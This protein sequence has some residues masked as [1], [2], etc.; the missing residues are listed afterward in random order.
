MATSATRPLDISLLPYS[1]RIL[2]SSITV[3]CFH[4]PVE[5]CSHYF[6][7][8]FHADHYTRLTKSFK[9]PVFCSETTAALVSS[10]IGA[11]A[12]GLEMYK[13]YGFDGFTV[14][15]IEANH[16]P[17]AVCFIFLVDGQLILH[18]G[19][20]RYNVRFHKFNLHFNCIYLDNTYQSV[21]VFPSQKD[22]ILRILGRFDQKNKL[23][24][25]RVCVLCCTYRIGKE[26]IFLS[27]AEYLNEKVQVDADKLETYRCYSQYSVDRINREVLGIVQD[28]RVKDETYFKRIKVNPTGAT[29]GVS[30]APIEAPTVHEGPPIICNDLLDKIVPDESLPD[31]VN[32]SPFSRIT[33]EDAMVKVIGITDLNKL[34]K[35][36][37]TVHADRIVVL[38]GSGWK[39]KEEFKTYNR[40]DGVKIKRGIEI[41]HF[42]YSEHSS[43]EELEMFKEHTTYDQIINTV[44]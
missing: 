16:C 5:N 12:I 18:T 40:M 19:D 34:D 32:S 31:N 7:S 37:S 41:V 4:T 27:V 22:A 42:R 38:C 23:C 20:F 21:A 15:L 10:R 36:I 30:I 11:T 43:S 13:T 6:L 33:T 26:K 14:R 44:N 9:H 17:G 3:D 2:D 28:M 25:P 1:K 29:K 39:E 8:H 24:M 35:I